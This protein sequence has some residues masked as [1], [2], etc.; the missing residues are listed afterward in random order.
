MKVRNYFGDIEK[1]SNI[2]KILFI[3]AIMVTM[4]LAGYLMLVLVYCIPTDS[5]T[6]KMQASSYILANE[7]TYTYITSYEEAQLDNWTDSLMLLTASHPR[8]ESIWKSAVHTTRYNSWEYSPCQVLVSLY[9]AD[10][11]E[12]SVADEPYSRYWHGYLVFLKPLLYFCSYSA[13]RY[14]M[15]FVQLGLFTLL[16]LKLAE[17]NKMLVFPVFLAWLFLNP[18]VTMMSLQYNSMFVV[19]FMAMLVIA[20][21][22]QRW[23]NKQLYIWGIF[24]LITGAVS[25]YMD[26]LTYPL[27]TLGLPLLLWLSLNYSESLKENL[28]KVISLSVF[29]AIGYSVMWG[30]KW[31]LGSIITGENILKEASDTIQF[32]TSSTINEQTFSFND[33]ISRQLRCS[34]KVLWIIVI[35]AILVTVFSMVISTK[36]QM[37][38]VLIPCLVVAVYPLAWYAVLK[39]HSYIHYWFTY[40]ELAI[41]LYAG[42]TFVV[43][44]KWGR[45]N[46]NG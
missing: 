44:Y 23:K 38:N 30:S 10:G 13:I 18:V 37:F 17:E 24:F 21:K 7:G 34:Y 29:W 16:I 2:K 22:N 31:I 11:T 27:V 46:A 4:C 8:N 6:S 19:T 39:N 25:S 3:P 20:Y 45:E 15:M 26:L 33:V 1:W 35:I 32:R 43:V 12:I 28:K 42:M 36:R 14:I 40:R 5:M 9:Q 41:A